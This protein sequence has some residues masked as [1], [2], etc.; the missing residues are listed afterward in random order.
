MTASV[1]TIW[2][3]EQMGQAIRGEIR[4]GLG[5]AAIRDVINA[6]AAPRRDMADRLLQRGVPKARWPASLDWDWARKRREEVQVPRWRGLSV[7]A[8]GMTQGLM[9]VSAPA[10]APKATRFGSRLLYIEYLE[11]APWNQSAAGGPRI[12]GVGS[13]LVVAA[14]ELSRAWGF[15]GRVGLHSLPQARGFYDRLGFV[16]LGPDDS[17]EGFSYFVMPSGAART[18]L[19][20]EERR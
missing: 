1:R 4:H 13:A 16:N 10:F 11:V 3:R 8:K 20:R 9:L 15:H 7:V 18:L 5:D 14:L 19:A 2:L 17:C 12:K 6:W